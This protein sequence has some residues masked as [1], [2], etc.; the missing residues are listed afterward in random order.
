MQFQVGKREQQSLKLH[1][2]SPFQS[3]ENVR[4]QKTDQSENRVQNTPIPQNHYFNQYQQVKRN[5][6]NHSE[7][8]V[9]HSASKQN[10]KP[11]HDYSIQFKVGQQRDKKSIDFHNDTNLSQL[12]N[13]KP[14]NC[15]SPTT[16]KDQS[17]LYQSPT[18]KKDIIQSP[19]L[20]QK[21]QYNLLNN[22]TLS[23]QYSQPQLVPMRQQSFTNT[24]ALQQ[25]LKRFQD[26]NNLIQNKIGTL[27][28]EISRGMQSNFIQQLEQKIKMLT[29]MNNKIEQENNSMRSTNLPQLKEQLHR[30]QNDRKI[31][32]NTL[33]QTNIDLQ[34]YTHKTDQL[35]NEINEKLENKINILVQ[36]LETK[37]QGLIQENERLNQKLAAPQ[38]I[39]ELNKLKQELQQIQTKFNLGKRDEDILKQKIT[40]LERQ[41]NSIQERSGLIE[42]NEKIQLLVEENQRLSMVVNDTEYSDQDIEDLRERIRIIKLD[43]MKMEKQMKRK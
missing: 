23:N 36:E 10:I 7:P 26:D 15:M 4:Q 38:P 27:E 2:R 32:Q 9:Q 3:V 6:S 13:Q 40:I 25:E 19:M 43:N 33:N 29:Q 16:N 31:M 8:K 21:Q 37:V 41:Y 22:T 18:I 35:Q 5:V 1:N 34:N 11:A 24:Q 14:F 39:Q 28:N 30:L 42:L 17:I 20:T 12:M